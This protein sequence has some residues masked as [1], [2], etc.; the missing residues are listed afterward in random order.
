MN[1]ASPQSNKCTVKTQRTPK[2]PTF[3]VQGPAD[4]SIVIQDNLIYAEKTSGIFSRVTSIGG[5]A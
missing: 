1:R 4:T 2:A 3:E 5:G